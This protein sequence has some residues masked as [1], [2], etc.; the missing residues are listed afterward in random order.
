MGKFIDMTGWV[1]KEHGVPDSRLTVTSR[2]EDAI[3]PKTG[4]H[5][6]MWNC[7]CS[8][9]RHCVVSTL[10]LRNTVRP[11]KSCGCINEE[12]KWAE[13]QI[14]ILKEMYLDGAK[15]SDIAQK[16]GKTNGAISSKA[17]DLGLSKEIIRP[18]NPKFKAVYQDYDWCFERFINQGMSMQ[19]MAEEAGASLRVIQKWCQ[20]IHDLDARS[21]KK[22]KKLNDIQKQL[23]MFGR[24]GD[25][26]IDRRENQPMYIETHADNQKD[27]I[28]WKWS[29]LKDICNKEPVYYPP[30]QHSFGGDKV[31]EC[32]AHY[33]ICTRI[34][35]DLKPIRAMS[36]G[37]ILYQLNEFGL[38]VHALDDGFRSNSNWEI[39]LAEW[40][41]EEI[42]LYLNICKK[43][44][45][46][47][48]YR[49]TDNRYIK[50]TA[51][52][53]RRLDEIILSV[54]PNN[55]DIIRYK[56]LDRHITK[57]QDYKYVIVND[58]KIG[59]STFCKQN[60][61][62]ELQRLFLRQI[63]VDNNINDISE[64]EFY[65]I[66]EEYNE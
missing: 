45:D 16:I 54:V 11:T 6:V 64:S 49:L 58:E 32:R 44:F 19:E 17:D 4:K 29:I 28:Y 56:I 14:S 26:H 13:E 18:N 30:A 55:L 33:R 7:D 59:L 53:S 60:G 50:F 57:R 41:D 3:D 61:I 5:K 34:I 12:K 9:G 52:S 43:R 40:N 8:C 38:S 42:E 10:G 22:H 39:C 46:L 35:D 27:Y 31:Y 37:E 47:D 63:L 23:V 2:A 15:I 48:G 51:E 65:K 25:G 36:I 62:Q 20:E 24:L 1:M 21:Y 66:M